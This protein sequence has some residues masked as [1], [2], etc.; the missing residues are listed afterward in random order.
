MAEG[1]PERHRVGEAGEGARQAERREDQLPQRIVNRAAGDRLDDSAGERE[2]GVVVAP[3]LAGLCQ[4]R[5]RR[6]GHRDELRQRF[7]PAIL[8]AQLPFPAGRVRQQVPQRDRAARLLVQ[9]VEVGQIGPHR[10][11]QVHAPFLHQ[12]HHRGGGDGL[13]D[14]RDGEQRVGGDRLRIVEAGDAEAAQ[15]LLAVLEQPEA[16]AGDA[17]LRHLRG[18]QRGDLVD[19]LVGPGLSL[20]V[21]TRRAKRRRRQ[22]G[23]AE[24]VATMHARAATSPGAGSPARSA[25]RQGSEPR[26]RGPP[27]A[28]ADRRTAVDRTPRPRPRRGRRTA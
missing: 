13:G 21:H 15:R 27:P 7:G 26:H 22:R 18:D 24:E 4:L 8:G 2:A 5:Q 11:A 10:R 12:P 1:E 6:H 16:D 17:V 28:S 3:H 25:S 20:G 19:A 9:D 14:R 23:Q